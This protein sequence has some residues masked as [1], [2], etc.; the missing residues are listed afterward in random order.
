MLKRPVGQHAGA[1]PAAA[2]VMLP[3]LKVAALL[4][5]GFVFLMQ[6]VTMGAVTVASWRMIKT[7]SPLVT[8]LATLP[9][10]PTCP[11]VD[12]HSGAVGKAGGRSSVGESGEAMWRQSC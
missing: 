12:V 9:S 1:V 11:I 8:F 3:L 6:M 4:Q 2:R 10:T 7:P 5:T